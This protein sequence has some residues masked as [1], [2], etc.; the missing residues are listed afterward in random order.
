MVLGVVML[1]ALASG[2]LVA[3]P[4]QRETAAAKPYVTA[5]IRTPTEDDAVII[6]VI[7][8]DP[9]TCSALAKLK[10]GDALSV[11]GRAKLAKWQGREGERTGLQMVAE[12]ILTAYQ[13]RSKRSAR[14]QNGTCAPRHDDRN[15]QDDEWGDP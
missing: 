13:A 5:Q 8:F 14:K 6:S 11:T 9:G 4:V 3:N 7:A 2:T 1:S 12:A 15:A 10:K